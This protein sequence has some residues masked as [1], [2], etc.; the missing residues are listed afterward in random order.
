MGGGGRG[1]GDDTEAQ[2]GMGGGAGGEG[3]TVG[4]DGQTDLVFDFDNSG[5]SKTNQYA[6]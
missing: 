6:P 5:P 2:A 1:E 4:T 3:G